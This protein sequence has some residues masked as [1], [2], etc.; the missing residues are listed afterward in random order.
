MLAVEVV[1]GPQRGTQIP[2][3]QQSLVAWVQNSPIGQSALLEHC[4]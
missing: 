2:V 4:W 3:K 1:P